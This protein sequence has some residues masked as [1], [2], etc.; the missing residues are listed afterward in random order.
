MVGLGNPGPRY[1]ETRHNIGAWV[2]ERLAARLDTRLRKVRFISV[3]AAEARVD[4]DRVWLLRPHAFMNESGPPVGS[5]VRRR[6]IDVE[7][8]VACHDDIDLPLGALKLKLG[9]STAG[10]RGLNSV[11]GALHSPGFHR[12]RLGIGRP[13]GRKEPA[14]HV[15]E[16]FARKEREEAELLAEDGADAVFTLIKEGLAAAQERFNR[17]GPPGS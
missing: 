4:D 7:R 17:S 9:G 5:F 14:D 1:T 11:A 13:S 16:T 6:K 15:L 3:D 8:V 10:H 2:V 12:V